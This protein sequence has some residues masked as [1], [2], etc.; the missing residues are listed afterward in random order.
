MLKTIIKKFVI[1]SIK[2]NEELNENIKKTAITWLEDEQKQTLIWNYYKIFQDKIKSMKLD[3][4]KLGINE[5]SN[6]PVNIFFGK[7]VIIPGEKSYWSSGVTFSSLLNG[8]VLAEATSMSAS[9]NQ[10]QDSFGIANRVN[11]FYSQSSIT[12]IKMP[13]DWEASALKIQ[14]AQPLANR[15]RLRIGDTM[16]MSVNSLKTNEIADIRIHVVIS[17]FMPND[18]VTQNVYFEKLIILRFLK[19]H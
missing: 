5:T 16:F 15:Y 1:P 7:T 18:L 13:N 14:I 12:K 9:R 19:I 3:L 4:D 11:D 2:E 10:S 8:D 17:G 6:F